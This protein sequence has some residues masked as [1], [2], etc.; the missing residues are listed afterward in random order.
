MRSL[1]EINAQFSTSGFVTEVFLL[2]VPPPPAPVLG[3]LP[4]LSDLPVLWTL[5]I[6]HN[7]MYFATAVLGR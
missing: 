1:L 3:L 7:S 2:L 5:Q 6:L 4:V